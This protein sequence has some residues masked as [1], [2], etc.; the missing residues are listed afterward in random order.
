MHNKITYTIQY[1]T[2]NRKYKTTTKSFENETHYE[3]W[4]RKMESFGHKIIGTFNEP[5][6]IPQIRREVIDNFDELQNKYLSKLKVKERQFPTSYRID[7]IVD[8]IGKDIDQ[9]N[10]VFL[11]LQKDIQFQLDNFR[12]G[13]IEKEDFFQAMDEILHGKVEPPIFK[14]NIIQK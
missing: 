6:K 12:N 14:D 10:E 8:E 2:L 5:K 11:I 1:K 3:N 4:R 9:N 7:E 13:I